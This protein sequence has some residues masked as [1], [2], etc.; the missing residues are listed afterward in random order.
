[1]F[2]LFPG[3]DDTFILHNRPRNNSLLNCRVLLLALLHQNIQIH[4]REHFTSQIYV[5]LF[6]VIH[7]LFVDFLAAHVLDLHQKEVLFSLFADQSFVAALEEIFDL[8]FLGVHP[9]SNILFHISDFDNLVDGPPE[10][11]IGVKHALQNSAEL[12]RDFDLNLVDESIEDLSF[13]DC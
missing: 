13:G 8:E 1:L 12:R 5:K 6:H 4:A 9:L 11:L 10:L 3:G 7:I 2:D